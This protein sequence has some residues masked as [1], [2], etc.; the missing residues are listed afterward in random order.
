MRQCTAA[1]GLLKYHGQTDGCPATQPTERG[2]A[3]IEGGG[4]AQRDTH[5]AFPLRERRTQGA[6]GSGR[7]LEQTERGRETQRETEG[8]GYRSFSALKTALLKL[9]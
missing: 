1:P 3:R 6:A 9:S 7:E 2:T 8:E 5:G 4:E